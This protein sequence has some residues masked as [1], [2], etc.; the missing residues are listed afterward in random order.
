MSVYATPQ[1]IQLFSG[2]LGTADVLENCFDLG[3][4]RIARIWAIS[5]EAQAAHATILRSVQVGTVADPDRYAHLTNDSD[6]TSDPVTDPDGV[7][8]SSAWTAD[9][10]KELDFTDKTVGNAPTAA[11]PGTPGGS[12]PEHSGPLLVT[13]THSGTTPTASRVTVGM[14]F[15]P[16]D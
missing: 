16:S 3:K 6:L 8:V 5:E 2:E 7:I 10:V 12:F 9:V 1:H 14:E 4:I 13:V 11:A 15:F